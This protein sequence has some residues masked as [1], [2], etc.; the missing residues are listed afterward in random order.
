V[1]WGVLA[2]FTLVLYSGTISN[3]DY[4]WGRATHDLL[5]P[6]GFGLVGL[7]I[8]CLIA[9]LMAS[10]SAFMLTAAALVTNNLYRPFSPNRSE[11]HYI[12]V[13]R[14]FSVLYVIVSALIATRSKGLFGLFKMTMMF[15]CIL[16]AAFWFGML[17]RK[18]NRAG[19][20]TSMVIMFIA[21]VV[22]PFGLPAIPGVR[23]SEY[24]SKTTSAIPVSRTYF[25][26]EMDVSERDRSIAAWDNL[27]NRGKAEGRR[28][29]AL[30]EG[31]EFEKKVLLP[32]KSVFWSEGFE[33][34]DG[35][36]TGAGNLKVE[37]IALDKMGW[38]LSENSYSLN[39]TLTFLF[40][41]II[42]FLIMMLAALVTKPED[43]ERLDQF[44][45]KMLT[46]VVGSHED[47]ARAMV[48]TRSNPNRYNNLKLFPG[49]DWE[50]RK[51]NRE[52]WLGI[53]GTFLAVFSVILLLLLIVNLGS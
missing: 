9:A 10:K 3:P 47:D 6:L 42:P 39:E 53:G 30:S 18:A 52:D 11:A 51:W 32:R 37:L 31:K 46:P 20:W 16:A 13:G 22:L 29:D 2:L 43:K 35:K 19:A 40:R 49:S 33:V 34:I 38:D 25:A 28:P 8:A 15:N 23:T 26:S 45:G 21:T 41:I 36:L 50:F 12:F 17:W 14:V 48:L 44:Y 4:V 5:G 27:N 1:M 7:M 24:L